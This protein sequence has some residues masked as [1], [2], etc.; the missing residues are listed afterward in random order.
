MTVSIYLQL[1]F[2]EFHLLFVFSDVNE[3][4]IQNGDCEHQCTDFTGG[5]VCSCFKGFLL[6][7]NAIG[8]NC[9]GELFFL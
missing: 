4:S 7:S 3:C 5:H 1:A 8:H 9:T 2:M 6:L